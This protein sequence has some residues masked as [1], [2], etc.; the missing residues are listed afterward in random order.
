MFQFANINFLD[1]REHLRRAHFPHLQCPHEGCRVCAGS[2][3]EIN[4]H[5]KKRHPPL[6]PLPPAIEQTINLDHLQKH[7]ALSLR[8][9]TWEEISEICFSMDYTREVLG[10][11]HSKNGESNG[12]EIEDE[13]NSR[14]L[15]LIFV[16]LEVY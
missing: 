15:L 6:Q 14:D 13:G 5:Q 11:I 1:S 12:D 7:R 3:F 8:T 9:L 4:R 2:K 10:E 16:F